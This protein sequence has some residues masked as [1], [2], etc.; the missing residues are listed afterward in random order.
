MLSLTEIARSLA[1][2][3]IP[4]ASTT[5]ESHATEGLHASF[6]NDLAKYG[7]S[8]PGAGRNAV[9]LV[10]PV[11]KAV[12]G[13]VSTVIHVKCP[14]RFL[15][16][17]FL[18]LKEICQICGGKDK[19]DRPVDYITFEKYSDIN[20][21]EDPI[22]YLSCGHFFTVGTFDGLMEMNEAYHVD[23]MTNNILFPKPLP[24][25]SKT[26]S[27]PECRQPLLDIHRYNRVVKSAFLAES[28]KRFC[29]FAQDAYVKLYKEVS[30]KESELASDTG[31]TTFLA[32]FIPQTAGAAPAAANLLR[33]LEE[34]GNLAE[35]PI[36]PTNPR[37]RPRAMPNDL[38]NQMNHILARL[39]SSN[40][41][42]QK[43]EAFVN[44]ATEA[45]QPYGKVYRLVEDAKKR[46]G[47]ESS[48]QFDNS[49]VQLSYHLKGQALYLQLKWANHWD[50]HNLTESDRIN[51]DLRRTIRNQT[52]RE[53]VDL[54]ERCNGLLEISALTNSVA[55]EV[56]ARIY[57]A[58]FSALQLLHAPAAPGGRPAEAQALMNS[59]LESLDVCLRFCETHQ[60]TA[61]KYEPEIEKAKKLLNGGTFYSFVSDAEKKLIFEAMASTMSGTGHWY[62]CENGHLFAIANCGMP[63]ELARCN[64]CGARVGGQN[65]RAVAGVQSAG[66]FER[67]FGNMQI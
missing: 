30:D 13:P 51:E 63:M 58:K 31:R 2:G 34:T 52:D 64:E 17:S 6:V 18:A 44:F 60:G 23:P 48:F 57:R 14:A 38:F 21:D 39:R 20:L 12:T 61:G 26:K 35:E 59:E 40:L 53:L 33:L 54:R 15:A 27:C 10:H 8:I 67:R 3:I 36:Q 62:T 16:T 4:P 7:V 43:V 45:E 66:D 32:R 47:V 9:N 49:A 41:L 28:T 56:E 24:E 50:A 29:A 55:Y 1:E 25:L 5:V 42:I 11:P 22:I 65:H 46:R 37:A 19:L